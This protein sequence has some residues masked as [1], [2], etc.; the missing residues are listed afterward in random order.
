MGRKHFPMQV[1]LFV[2]GI[3]EHKFLHTF[4]SN[5]DNLTLQNAFG[6]FST[7]K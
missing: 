2:E 5:Q 6:N 1:V 7:I 3:F 4:R